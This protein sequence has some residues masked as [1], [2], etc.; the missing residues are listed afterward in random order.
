MENIKN[1]NHMV[2]IMSDLDPEAKVTKVS[3]TRVRATNKQTGLN[4]TFR[5][6]EPEP[7]MPKGA[8]ICHNSVSNKTVLMITGWVNPKTINRELLE[9]FKE[10]GCREATNYTHTE[11]GS[12]KIVIESEDELYRVLSIAAN[13]IDG[14]N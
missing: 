14:M 10:H 5:L 4:L 1:I 13:V 9:A 3:E 8:I 12:W 11:W 7:P 6:P 2:E